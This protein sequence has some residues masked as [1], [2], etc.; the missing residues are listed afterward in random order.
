M[1]LNHPTELMRF[2]SRL[3]LFPEVFEKR[4]K[5]FRRELTTLCHFVGNDRWVGEREN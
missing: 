4:P 1:T 3:W 2:A 5:V